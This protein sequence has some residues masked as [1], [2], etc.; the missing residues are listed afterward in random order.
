MENTEKPAAD[1]HGAGAKICSIRQC[2][3]REGQREPV[4]G[5]ESVWTVLNVALTTLLQDR[6][7]VRLKYSE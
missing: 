6:G 4:R 5:A 2:A 3:N 1:C 7:E